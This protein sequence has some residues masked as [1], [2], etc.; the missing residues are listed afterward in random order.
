[1]VGVLAA[2]AVAC[3]VSIVYCMRHMTAEHIERSAGELLLRFGL[4]QPR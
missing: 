1:V 3:G 2:G 4:G